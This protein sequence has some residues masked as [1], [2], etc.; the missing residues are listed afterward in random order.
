MYSKRCE[1]I[2]CSSQDLTVEN[3][4][5]INGQHL[6]PRSTEEGSSAV[7]FEPRFACF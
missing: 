5:K 7:C 1:A 3:G 4:R 2:E 6:S